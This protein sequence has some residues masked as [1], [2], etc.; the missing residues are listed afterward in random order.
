MCTMPCK[1]NDF[2]STRHFSIDPIDKGKCADKCN[3]LSATEAGGLSGYAP[4]RK[5][6]IRSG[7]VCIGRQKGP[8]PPQSKN[9]PG[10]TTVIRLMTTV[11]VAATSSILGRYR[12]PVRRKSEKCNV[13]WQYLVLSTTP[14]PSTQTTAGSFFLVRQIRGQNS[15]HPIEPRSLPKHHLFSPPPFSTHHLPIPRLRQPQLAIFT[16]TLLSIRRVSVI[17]LPAA[18]T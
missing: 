4:G 16:A 7:Q 15:F 10:F 3:R 2:P 9:R 6:L 14:P 17:T 1:C 11:F 18:S 13:P 12:A 5:P 8:L